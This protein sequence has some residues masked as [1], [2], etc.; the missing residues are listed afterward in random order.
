MKE[1]CQ[2]KGGEQCCGYPAQVPTDGILRT[3]PPQNNQHASLCFSL[4]VAEWVVVM[5]SLSRM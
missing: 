2:Q 4:T 5:P 3:E 1:G